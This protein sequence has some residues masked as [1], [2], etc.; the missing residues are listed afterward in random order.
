MPVLE[1]ALSVVKREGATPSLHDQL[2]SALSRAAQV[3]EDSRV[4]IA[5]CQLVSVALRAT[6]EDSH[7]G[8]AARAAVRPDG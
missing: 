4:L 7:R 8:R 6:V 2:A 3:Q 5:E 1:Q